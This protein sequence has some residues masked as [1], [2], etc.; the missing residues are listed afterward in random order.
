MQTKLNDMEKKNLELQ[1]HSNNLTKKLELL[2]NKHKINIEKQKQKEEE[3][4]RTIAYM[5]RDIAIDKAKINVVKN[6]VAKHL[7]E[8]QRTEPLYDQSIYIY[9]WAN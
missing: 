3:R 4:I 6:D 9:V 1:E 5:E 7:R 8:Y 2:N